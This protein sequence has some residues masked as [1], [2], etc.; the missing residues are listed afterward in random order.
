MMRRSGFTLMQIAVVAAVLT[1]LFAIIAPVLA[2]AQESARRTTCAQNLKSIHLAVTL[3]RQEEGRDGVYGS[4]PD[5][6]LPHVTAVRGIDDIRC[7]GTNII[8]CS[9]P[10]LGYL[11]N[12]GLLP[13]R[14]QPDLEWKQYVLTYEDDAVLIIDANHPLSCPI[15]PL[16]LNRGIGVNLGGAIVTRLRR[17]DPGKKGWW[18][19]PPWRYKP[20]EDLVP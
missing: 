10:S 13:D 4:W 15:T 6:G 11:F 16:S 3:Y 18:H 7:Q 2:R 9:G 20:H 17:G 5:M 8:A 1:I 19:D 14:T 12:Y